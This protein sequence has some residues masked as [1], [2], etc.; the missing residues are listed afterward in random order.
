MTG[1]KAGVKAQVIGYRGSGPLLGDLLGGQVPVAFDTLDGLIPQH[2]AGKLR[3]LAGS[4]A[5]RSPAAP[6]VPT[7]KEAGLDLVATGF[8]AFFA[9]ATMPA[10]KVQQYAEAIRDIMRDPDTQKKF[11]DAKMTP[12]VSTQA[13]TIAMLKAY[14]AQWGP[15]VQKSGYQ[16]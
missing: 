6:N 8:N 9:P 5:K 3:I 7:F 2:E 15:V 11:A 16:P 10:A 4:G 13:Q 14:R 12:V 1:E